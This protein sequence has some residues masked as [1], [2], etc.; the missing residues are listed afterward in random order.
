MNRIRAFIFGT[1]VGLLTMPGCAR[2]DAN[3]PKNEGPEKWTSNF[4][5][6][7]IEFEGLVFRVRN[8]S[9]TLRIRSMIDS[10]RKE[11]EAKAGKAQSDASFKQAKK[12]YELST[13]MREDRN[14][15]YY[16]GSLTLVENRKIILD[17]G[18]LLLTI[19]TEDGVVT[20]RDA[21]I[22]FPKHRDRNDFTDSGLEPATFGLAYNSLHPGDEN[23]IQIR[24]RVFGKILKVTVDPERIT[25]KD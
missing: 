22:L 21:G 12:G 11:M 2:V 10:V 19:Q 4:E 9:D 5:G 13:A 25:I 6:S 24:S 3:Y 16:R 23:G 18:C 14:H 20:I 15:V 1:V 17:K 8:T 7:Q